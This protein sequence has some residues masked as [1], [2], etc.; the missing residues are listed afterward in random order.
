MT[1]RHERYADLL[2]HLID[3]RLTGREAA[4]VADHL[5][6]CEECRDELEAITSLRVAGRE[7]P[8]EIAPSRDLWEGIAGRIADSGRP[9]DVVD[10]SARRATLERRSRWIP[11]AAAA[12]L[13]VVLS[14]GMTVALLRAPAGG[15]AAGIGDSVAPAP[16]PGRSETAL[17]AFRPTQA[18]Y[19]RLIESLRAQ[20]DSRRGSLAPETVGVIENNL[21]II[22]RAIAE[23]HAALEA[24]PSSTELPLHLSHIY[25]RKVE[26]LRSATQIET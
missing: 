26:L 6:G 5:S 3:G 7:L 17:V 14:S 2:D 18:E 16:A 13:L 25:G 19:E 22:D 4:R 1:M 21:R 11:L 10:I 23:A 9:A 24:D 8:R 15:P 12:V 20:L